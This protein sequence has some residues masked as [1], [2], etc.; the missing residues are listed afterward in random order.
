MGECTIAALLAA[1]HLALNAG[2]DPVYGSRTVTSECNKCKCPNSEA[3]LMECEAEKMAVEAKA[4]REWEHDREGILAL[5]E[6][7]EDPK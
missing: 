2:G 6:A 7:C 1:L 4:Q 3:D 5:I